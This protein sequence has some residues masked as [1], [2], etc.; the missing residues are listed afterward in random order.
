MSIGDGGMVLAI[1]LTQ[2]AAGAVAA[3]FHV[4]V[5]EITAHAY[6]NYS[7]QSDAFEPSSLA[8]GDR[9]VD[10]GL[11]QFHRRESGR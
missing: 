5:R 7:K 2:A 10:V 9:R 8:G 11:G 3:F 6:S 1:P 4:C